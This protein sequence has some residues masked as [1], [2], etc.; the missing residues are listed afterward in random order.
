MEE[1]RKYCFMIFAIAILTLV[2]IQVYS[3]PNVKSCITINVDMAFDITGG[4]STYQCI[5]FYNPDETGTFVISYIIT[6]DGEGIT[7]EIPKTMVIEKQTKKELCFTVKTAFNLAPDQYHINITIDRM[8]EQ[9]DCDITVQA[10]HSKLLNYKH[11]YFKVKIS[12]AHQLNGMYRGWCIDLDSHMKDYRKYSSTDI[13]SYD[14]INFLEHPE[15][16]DLVNYILN[17]HYIGQKSSCS[18]RYTYGDIQRAIWALLEDHQSSISLLG[19]WT[20]CRAN[21]IIADAYAHGEGYT[22]GNGDVIGV[23]LKPCDITKAQICIIEVP[24]NLYQSYTST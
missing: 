12:G 5:E 6:P 11:S 3:A 1:K 14:T 22:P 23:I 20:T 9:Q 19:S 16:L 4:C 2:S 21:K 24:F 10:M 15:N 17:K 13:S 7:L 8:I 18:G